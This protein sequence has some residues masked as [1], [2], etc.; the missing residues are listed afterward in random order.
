MPPKNFKP[1]TLSSLRQTKARRR[2]IIAARMSLLN[3]TK[4]GSDHSVLCTTYGRIQNIPNMYPVH[5]P[6]SL[7]SLTAHRLLLIRKV[8]SDVVLCQGVR[9]QLL[10][11]Q[12]CL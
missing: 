10:Y 3:P 5:M 7:S 1:V 11:E 6:S 2:V 9:V 12:R 8:R 4:F